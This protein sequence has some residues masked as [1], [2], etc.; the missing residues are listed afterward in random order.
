MLTLKLMKESWIINELKE[1]VTT[2]R[3]PSKSTL[4]SKE[5]IRKII[6]FGATFTLT[7]SSWIESNWKKTFALCKRGLYSI[8]SDLIL[9]IITDSSLLHAATVALVLELL[10]HGIR[11]FHH[12]RNRGNLIVIWNE[13]YVVNNRV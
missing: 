10:E 4:M 6:D 11:F 1:L 5:L 3:W 7:E 8:N 13:F 9:S 2:S 12:K